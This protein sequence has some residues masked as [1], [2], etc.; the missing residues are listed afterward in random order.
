[1]LKEFS[2]QG[3]FKWLYISN[4]LVQKYNNTKHR[5]IN[6]KPNKVNSKNENKLLS[7]VF[8]K[9]KM[10][11][12]GRYK[13]GDYVR[14][15]KNRKIFDKG[16]TPNWSTEIFR[17]YKVR[18]TNPVTYL[19]KDYQN[20]PILGGFYEF[21]LQKVKNP[22]T[23]LIE[24]VLKRRGEQAYVKWLGFDHSTTHG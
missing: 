9:I 2:R 1:M 13:V 24:K 21:E 16:Y 7:T 3:H 19:E 5:T 10:F 12:P 18:I 4:T 23:Y 15:S 11:L 14:I 20:Q 17:I 8:N 6:M 22:D